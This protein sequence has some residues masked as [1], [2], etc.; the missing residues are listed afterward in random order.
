MIKSPV[1]APDPLADLRPN[2]AE[3][4][5]ARVDSLSEFLGDARKGAVPE[6]AISESHRCVHSMISSAAIFGHPELSRAAR[7]AEQAFER[8]AT[9]GDE[10]L[11][12]SLEALLDA[13]SH[14]LDVYEKPNPRNRQPR[15]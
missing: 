3:R 5:C 7:A 6:L 1:P 9:M 12:S 2:Y 10:R 15:N 4:L 8:R 13:A 11:I 14:V